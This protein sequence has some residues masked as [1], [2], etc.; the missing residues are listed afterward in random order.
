M[1]NQAT[2][3]R[4]RWDDEMN[5]WHIIGLCILSASACIVIYGAVIGLGWLA[6]V[7]S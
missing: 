7:I 2:K 4:K 3:Y 6:S 1:K 5:I